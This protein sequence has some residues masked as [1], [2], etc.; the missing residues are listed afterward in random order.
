MGYIMCPKCGAKYYLRHIKYPVKED[1]GSVECLDCKT[2][3]Y[4]WRK[5][6]DDY[7]LTRAEVEIEKTRQE[8]LIREKAPLCDCGIKMVQRYHGKRPFWGCANYPK[9]CLRK[10]VWTLD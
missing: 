10:L 8:D 9:G 2:T 6:T 7:I 1:G 5:G 3:L 4:T